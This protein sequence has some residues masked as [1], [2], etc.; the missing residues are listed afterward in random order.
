MPTIIT[1]GAANAKAF[2][3]NGA[4]GSF[5]IGQLIPNPS[6][7]TTASGVVGDPQGNVYYVGTYLPTSSNLYSAFAVKLDSFGNVV[8]QR[9]YTNTLN[10]LTTFGAKP[11][12]SNGYLYLSVN[13]G[14]GNGSGYLKIDAA[15]GLIS[16]QVLI[17]S[18]D[19][20]QALAMSSLVVDSADNVYIINTGGTKLFTLKFNSAG[21][22]QWTR[23]LTWPV[24][25]FPADANIVIGID[26]ALDSTNNLYVLGTV[27]HFSELA[28]R[29]ALL[30]KYNSNGVLQWQKLVA[31]SNIQSFDPGNSP[32]ANSLNVDQNDNIWVGGLST[33]TGVQSRVV[34]L[35]FDTSGTCSSQITFG[36]NVDVDYD[37]FTLDSS[38]NIYIIGY[39]YSVYVATISKISYTGNFIWTRT[40]NTMGV[41]FPGAN[42]TNFRSLRVIKNALH[43]QG[44]ST[45]ALSLGKGGNGNITQFI[46]IPLDGSLY[47]IY[48]TPS[49]FVTKFY[50][51][52]TNTAGVTSAVTFTSG[53]GVDSAGTT[54]LSSTA[55]TSSAF[56]AT[57]ST[58]KLNNSPYTI[59]RSVRLRSSAPAYLS[60]TF[61]SPT[62]STIF[63]WS[64]WVKRGTLGATSYLFGASTTTNL[65]FNSS[66]QLVLTLAGTT[67]VTTTAVY[68]D[69]SAW[70]HIVYTQNGAAQ[71]LYVNGNV[72]GTGTT[73]NTV[74]NT[75][76]AHQ[77]GAANTA[78]YFDGY[79]TEINFID[80]QALT[81]PSFGFLTPVT[82]QWQPIQYTGTYGANGFYINF[83]DNSGVTSTTLG[84]D[85][86]G[87]GNNWTP[88]NISITA[89]ATYDSMIDVPTAYWDGAYA[90]GNF[91]VLNPL[92]ATPAPTGAITNGNLSWSAAGS[93]NYARATSTF[94]ERADEYSAAFTREGM[95]FE[96]TITAGAPQIGVIQINDGTLYY[97]GYSPKGYVYDTLTGNKMNNNVS[98]A[99]GATATV[100][101]VISVR[102]YRTTLVFYK[103]GVSQGTA[104]NNLAPSV[105]FYYVATVG[106]PSTTTTMGCDINFG[107][108]PFV[109]AASITNQLSLEVANT[110]MPAAQIEQQFPNMANFVA[111]TV[112]TGTGTS[113]SVV[114]TVNNNPAYTD[115]VWVKG[116]SG[117]TDSAIYDSMRG[118]QKD[119]V[120][121]SSAAETTQA[122]GLTTFNSNGFSG[123]SLAKINTASATYVAWQWRLGLGSFVT[124]TAGSG[125]IATNYQ[126][127]NGFSMSISTY[128]G[129]GVAGVVQARG[130]EFIIVKSRTAANNWAVFHKDQAAAP[131]GGYLTLNS[132]AAYTADTTV[133]NNTLQVNGSATTVGTSALTNASG[134]SYIM[135][136]FGSMPGASMFNVYFGN[137]SAN[138][139]FVH[140]GFRPKI[141]IVKRADSTS[142]WFMWD[143][144]RSPI[145]VT[146]NTLYANLAAAADTS[147]V[148]VDFLANGFKLRSATLANVNGGRYVYA[149]WAENSFFFANAR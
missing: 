42:Q 12:Y 21:T 118:V 65:G 37:G 47:N 104:F 97:P 5:Y 146:S 87:N 35:K 32:Y 147:T 105:V 131:Q 77:I 138:G 132:T 23:V 91:S 55:I 112:Y 3:A 46:K 39:N 68:R 66:D 100:G 10:L 48:E 58:V 78:N 143:S 26:T 107:Q 99:Y 27:K 19:S 88:N 25:V 16:A 136:A 63:T 17:T 140:C 115:L 44:Y 103:N 6:W 84:K 114:N 144:T 134:G 94:I 90:R 50:N 79:L 14:S 93:A 124:Q 76:I 62:S 73:A 1:S 30:V 135:Y 29:H 142:D 9:T 137:G 56:S 45:L 38:G 41:C 11:A 129:T 96:V 72:A 4:S 109:Y 60:D 40:F 127:I 92:T 86:S 8:W 117:A 126:Y 18:V 33:E 75:A 67:A 106:N 125:F 128:T 59:S 28:Y 61:G 122:T 89:G 43:A 141:I 148:A 70:Y 7:S 64:G 120:S 74:F 82:N 85:Y 98:T 22:L 2:S 108:R 51:D 24:F 71:T 34:F 116:I 149:A 83:S 110:Y 13:S 81:P 52:T 102:F 101:D 139:P 15:T 80:G 53:T 49:D 20:I 31:A 123:G 95:Y 69:P 130:G 113:L 133:W 54:V 119:L 36:G 57:V 121:N 145:N 111:A